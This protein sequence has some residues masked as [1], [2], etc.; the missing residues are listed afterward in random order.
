MARLI[1]NWGLSD[2][3]KA[4]IVPPIPDVPI[5]ELV[6]RGDADI[7]FQQVSELLP[8]TGID[9]LGP[10]P[11]DIQEEVT[12]FSAGVHKAA[13]PT[14]AAHTAEIPHRP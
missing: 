3:L 11:A 8:V 14:D 9:Y 10:L 1:A 6:A 13:G 5:G 2:Q 4:K 7:G 12:V